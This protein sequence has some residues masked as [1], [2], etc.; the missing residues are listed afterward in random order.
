[1]YKKRVKLYVLAGNKKPKTQDETK[2]REESLPVWHYRIMNE[3][4][5]LRQQSS[6][7]LDIKAKMLLDCTSTGCNGEATRNRRRKKIHN[8]QEIL[9][10]ITRIRSKFNSWYRDIYFS[11][12]V[13]IYAL[14]STRNPIACSLLISWKVCSVQLDR[15][16]PE[17]RSVNMKLNH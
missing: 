9:S 12:M 16:L 5:K 17:N 14:S 2:K 4:R 10:K 3:D 7:V 11:W 1:M 13:L 15:S 6:C 8:F